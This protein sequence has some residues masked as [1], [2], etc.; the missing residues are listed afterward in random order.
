MLKSL[1]SWTCLLAVT[2]LTTAH[3]E[4]EDAGQAA[5]IATAPVLPAKDSFPAGLVSIPAGSNYYS[6]YAFVV[7]KK[8]RTLSVWQQ[9]GSELKQ[10][11]FFPADLGKREGDKRAENDHKTP[12]GIYFLQERLEGNS[13]DFKQYGKRAFTTDYPNYF[14]RVDGKTGSGIWL[15]AVPDNVPLTRG[16]RGCVVVRNDVILDLT[17]YVKLGRTPI[18]I[19]NQAETLNGA[20]REKR[21][22]DLTQW[23]ESWRAAWASKDIDAYIAFYDDAFK[24]LNMNKEEWKAYKARLNA[25]YKTIGVKLSKP[26]IYADR[27]RAVIRFLQQ[28]SS[29]THSDFGEKTLFLRKRDGGYRIVG[30]AWTMDQSK[31]AKEEIDRANP[32]AATTAAP[33]PCTGEGCLQTT[34]AH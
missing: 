5:S 14:D 2:C 22:A 8:A 28:Y 33:Q 32:S 10:V 16:S 6:P 4:S 24:S 27:D 11:A 17:Q 29:D 12:E 9:I 21:T 25:Q 20:E 13:L 3:A 7:D 23:L 1:I 30:E 26:A 18:L 15:H 31:L 34:S 19:Q